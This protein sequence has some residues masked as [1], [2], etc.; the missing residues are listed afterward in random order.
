MAINVERKLKQKLVNENWQFDVILWR[1][2]KNNISNLKNI[3]KFTKIK[4]VF[5]AINLI[6]IIK[7]QWYYCQNKKECL[8]NCRIGRQ[9]ESF[10]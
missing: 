5:K 7:T 10:H 6:K 1:S 9:K 3:T 8:I 2:F 4:I